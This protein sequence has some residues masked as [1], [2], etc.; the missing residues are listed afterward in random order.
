[1]NYNIP[2]VWHYQIL[3]S[4]EKK[5][6]HAAY[7]KDFTYEKAEMEKQTNKQVSEQ[8]QIELITK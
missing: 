3:E 2:C 7:P 1:M 4:M 5:Y 6:W 8:G